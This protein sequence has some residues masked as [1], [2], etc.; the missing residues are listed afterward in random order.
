MRTALFL[1]ALALLSGC[2]SKLKR[3]SSAETDHFNALK[4]FMNESQ[5][6]SFLK[7]KTE[8]ERNAYL[9]EIGMWDQFYKYDAEMRE[10]I[11]SGEVMEGWSEDRVFM[12]WG[13]PVS[14][15]RLTGRPA[16]RSELF[17]YRFEVDSEGYVRVWTPGSKTEY[18]AR[19]TYQLNLYI[20]DSRVAEIVK[21]DK[22]E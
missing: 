10:Q 13:N 3:L 8:D 22:W 19:S 15:K 11:L 9:K 7:Q 4:I 5:E 21:K 1:A 2:G 12:A 14:R 20:D 18:K 16:T 6:K 17:V